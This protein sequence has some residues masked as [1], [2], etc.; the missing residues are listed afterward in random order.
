MDFRTIT[1]RISDEKSDSITG[2]YKL[3]VGDD[4]TDDEKTQ[5]YWMCGIKRVDIESTIQRKMIENDLKDLMKI[6]KKSIRDYE[7][8][9]LKSLRTTVMTTT[10]FDRAIARATQQGIN[11]KM[12]ATATVKIK[13]QINYEQMLMF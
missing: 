6:A 2:F 11:F 4:R 8:I 10:R 7:T 9:R 5:P 3:S 12:P 1:Y 13:K